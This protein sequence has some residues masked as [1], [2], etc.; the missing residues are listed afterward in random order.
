VY[1]SIIDWG[2][3][4]INLMQQSVSVDKAA[5]KNKEIRNRLEAIDKKLRQILF[6]TGLKKS[7]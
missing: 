4:N 3:E 1:F 7:N 6:D 2:R 5:A